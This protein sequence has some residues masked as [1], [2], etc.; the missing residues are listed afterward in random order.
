[1]SGEWVQEKVVQ[2]VDEG[3]LEHGTFVQV[4]QTNLILCPIN[5]N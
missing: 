1:M 5:I 3:D 4:S 2:K